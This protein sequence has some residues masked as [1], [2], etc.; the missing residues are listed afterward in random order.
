MLTLHRKVNWIDTCT[1]EYVLYWVFTEYII[2]FYREIIFVVTFK[3]HINI[4]RQGLSITKREMYVFIKHF[5]PA[6]TFS[7]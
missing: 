1:S 5:A 6:A 3:H 2:L 7:E 4:D